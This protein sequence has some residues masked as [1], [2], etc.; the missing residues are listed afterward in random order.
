[1]IFWKRWD[2]HQKGNILSNF[3]QKQFF[4]FETLITSLKIWFVEGIFRLKSGL[5]GMF[6]TFNLSSDVDILAFF[7][8]GNCFGYFFQTL[9]DYLSDILVTLTA[10]LEKKRA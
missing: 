10:F 7:W 9:G 8:L 2:S 5:N 1:V 3:V 4:T 6:W